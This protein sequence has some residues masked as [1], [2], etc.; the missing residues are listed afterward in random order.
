MIPLQLMFFP[1]PRAGEGEGGG[2]DRAG[3]QGEVHEL[4]A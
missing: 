2:G 3:L 4:Q 1:S